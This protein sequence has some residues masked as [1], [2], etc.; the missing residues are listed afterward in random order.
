MKSLGV[1]LRY[2]RAIFLY[3]KPFC[4]SNISSYSLIMYLYASAQ[5]TVTQQTYP[6]G[7]TRCCNGGILENVA[8]VED[9][10]GLFFQR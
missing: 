1:C 5:Q 3:K 2:D 9:E 10:N 8:N 6:G 4:V 7:D